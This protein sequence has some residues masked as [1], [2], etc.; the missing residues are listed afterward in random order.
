MTTTSPSR[1]R[2]LVTRLAKLQ[3]GILASKLQP[4]SVVRQL[5]ELADWIDGEQRERPKTQ[6]PTGAELEVFEFWQRCMGKDAAKFTP[7]RRA[8]IRAR[9]S[10][11]YKI[12]DLKRAISNVSESNFH[13]GENDGARPYNDLTLILRTG[14]KLEEF[15]DIGN[16]APEPE[17]R[18]A[19]Q[20]DFEAKIRRLSAE[21]AQQMKEGNVDAYNDTQREIRRLRSGGNAS[22]PVR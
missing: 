20:S 2:E 6:Q 16:R 7:E 3:Y 14:T 5:R 12:E 4:P 9:L 17:R 21:G 22:G 13:M 8:K 1:T 15:R 10:E 18:G 11:G 19:P